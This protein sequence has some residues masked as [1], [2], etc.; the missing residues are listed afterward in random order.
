ME[1]KCIIDDTRNVVWILSI[2]T[3]RIARISQAP[4]GI[5]KSQSPPIFSSNVVADHSLY[6]SDCVSVTLL[7]SCQYSLSTSNSFA[8]RLPTHRFFPEHSASELVEPS[9][10]VMRTG[11]RHE[12]PATIIYQNSTWDDPQRM[13]IHSF[14]SS[15]GSD[16]FSI[17]RTGPSD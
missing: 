9:I 5:L 4:G 1:N 12:L 6:F 17:L 11:K 13:R 8:L 10:C 2:A 7:P 14:S 3:S 16:S 15:M